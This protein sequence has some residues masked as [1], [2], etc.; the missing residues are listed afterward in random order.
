MRGVRVLAA[1]VL[2]LAAL[3][4][5][6]AFYLPGVATRDYAKGAGTN[7]RMNA[8]R[9]SECMVDAGVAA[10]MRAWQRLGRCCL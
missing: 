5:A 9:Q 2:L 4:G 7:K 10:A 6:Q 3:V 8:S 1:A